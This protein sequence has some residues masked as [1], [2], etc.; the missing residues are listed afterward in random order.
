MRTLTARSRVA[1]QLVYT[2]QC[3][4]SSDSIVHAMSGV[5]MRE[6]MREGKRWMRVSRDVTCACADVCV[7]RGVEYNQGK[8]W[9]DGCSYTC[10]CD[11]AA[12]GHYTCTERCARLPSLPSTCT[13]VQDPK[14]LCCQVA[15]CPVNP[16]PQTVTPYTGPPTAAPTSKTLAPNPFVTPAPSP[17]PGEFQSRSPV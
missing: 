9:D 15:S 12:A 17:V 2:V 6:R 10:V 4:G 11:D 3:T 1:V 14:D 5:W 13:L 7:Y 16:T 8:T